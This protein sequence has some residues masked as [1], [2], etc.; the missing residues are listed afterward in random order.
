[1]ADVYSILFVVIGMLVATC[2]LNIWTALMFPG[3]VQRCRGRLEKA[4]YV[5]FWLGVLYAGV[6]GT[7]GI[8]ALNAPPALVKMLAPLLLAPLVVGAVIGGAGLTT[9]LGERMGALNKDAS[10][11]SLLIRGS[12]VNSLS[13]FFPV[14]GWFFFWPIVTLVGIG[15]GLTAVVR[16]PRPSRTAPVAPPASPSPAASA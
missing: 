1:M 16:R 2:S 9:L 10:P 7:L 13:I 4:P 5:S 15:A 6:L 8:M 3:P 12:L 11:F 14:I